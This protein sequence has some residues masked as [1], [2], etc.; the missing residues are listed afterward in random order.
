MFLIIILKKTYYFNEYIFAFLLLYA[1]LSSLLFITHS[2][3]IYYILA[4]LNIS[5]LNM[6]L[7]DI[8]LVRSSFINI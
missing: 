1:S 3:I 7:F 5:Y 4:A 2:I 6:Y 8:V